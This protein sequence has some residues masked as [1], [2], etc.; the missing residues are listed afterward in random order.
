MK[1]ALLSLAMTAITIRLDGADANT[2]YNHMHIEVGKK[3]MKTIYDSNLNIVS[4][5][6]P[7]AHIRIQ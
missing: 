4:P 2:P 1:F 5:R 7:K 3:N 6:S